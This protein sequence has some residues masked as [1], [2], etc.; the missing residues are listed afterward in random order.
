M[1][2]NSFFNVFL[3]PIP[4]PYST[5]SDSIRIRKENKVAWTYLK[6]LF[7]MSNQL[8]NFIVTNDALEPF[9]SISRNNF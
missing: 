6:V 9:N 8:F 2:P 4:D 3:Y 7:I 1:Y 5:I